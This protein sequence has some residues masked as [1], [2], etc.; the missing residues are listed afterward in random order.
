FAR[1]GKMILYHGNSDQG[2]A[3]GAVT[4]WYDAVLEDNGEGITHSVRLFLV[5]GMAHCSGGR[6]T[7]TFDLL[8]AIQTW[9]EE[10]QAPERILATG[11][12]F[13]GVSRPLCPYPLVARYEGG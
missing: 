9:V 1:H 8:T 5:P 12:A 10:G 2:M 4:D 11:E 3:T 13:P 6:S 7:D